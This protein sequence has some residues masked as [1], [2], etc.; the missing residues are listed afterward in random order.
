[1]HTIQGRHDGRP[2]GDAGFLHDGGTISSSDFCRR[3]F[4]RLAVWFE[5]SR[6]RRALAKLDD[7][8]LRDIGVSRA[9]ANR[10]AEKPFWRK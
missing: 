10:E 5:R 1:M 4:D 2:P 7:R 9:D 6:Q 8:M 3:L